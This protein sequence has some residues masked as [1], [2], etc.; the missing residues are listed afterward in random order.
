MVFNTSGTMANVGVMGR[1]FF[2]FFG[3]FVPD[4]REMVELLY[5]FEDPLVLDGSKFANTFP[6]FKYTPHE[7]AVRQTVEW[8][9]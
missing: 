1:G 8:F 2:R 4:A 6:S 3:L 9:R 5:E 7:D